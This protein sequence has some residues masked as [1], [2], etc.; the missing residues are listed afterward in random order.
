MFIARAFNNLL[1]DWFT[2]SNCEGKNTASC[3]DKLG[4]PHYL[5]PVHWLTR[6]VFF[7]T[8]SSQDLGWSRMLQQLHSLRSHILTPPNYFSHHSPLFRTISAV[9]GASTLPRSH[10]LS[11]NH[12]LPLASHNPHA[13][14]TG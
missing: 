4:I 12:Q 7:L 2:Y 9:Y 1:R 3:C 8:H 6:Q 11:S 10:F 14:H 13:P 5:N